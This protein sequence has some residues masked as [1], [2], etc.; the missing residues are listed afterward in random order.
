M[1]FELVAAIVVG[2]FGICV[3]SMVCNFIRDVNER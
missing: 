2:I 1:A 3:Y